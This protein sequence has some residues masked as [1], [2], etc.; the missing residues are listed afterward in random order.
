VD[1]IQWQWIDKNLG[2]FGEEDRNIRLGLAID[3]VN[4]YRVKS[5][6]WSS[7]PVCL[8]NYNVPSWFTTKKHFIMLFMIIPGKESVTF[9][10]FDVYL[11]P[12][13]EVLQSFWEEGVWTYD[14]AK[15]GGSSWFSM[16]ANLMWTI[17]DFPAYGI[18]AGCVTKGYK[19][20]PI[21]GPCTIS[22]RSVVL[23]K[24][25]NDNQGCRWLPRDHHWRRT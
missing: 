8:L 20:Y 14:A 22:R 4:P 12:L 19:S 15:Y 9:E 25:L 13:I 6:S 21:C 3:G 10:T 7:W 18:A 17:Y 1:S 11:Q 2:H 24:N 16:R 23:K 5:S